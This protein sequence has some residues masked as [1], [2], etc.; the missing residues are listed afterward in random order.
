M[1]RI[2]KRSA[3]IAEKN[4][5]R[6]TNFKGLFIVVLVVHAVGYILRY[7]LGFDMWLIAV[8]A[9]LAAWAFEHFEKRRVEAEER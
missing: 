8:A 1:K 9:G 7:F 2:L 4:P 6:P 5:A 3:E